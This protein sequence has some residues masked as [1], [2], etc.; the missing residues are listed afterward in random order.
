MTLVSDEPDQFLASAHDWPTQSHSLF[1]SSGVDQ[2]HT[3]IDW[4][5]GHLGRRLGYK[6]AAEMLG[7]AMVDAHASDRDLLVFPWLHC[8]RHWLELELKNLLNVC[9]RISG[10]E[11][12]IRRSHKVLD[13]WRELKPMLKRLRPSD[14]VAEMQILDRLI[15]EMAELDPDSMHSRYPVLKDGSPTLTTRKVL[16]V[17]E[18]HDAMSGIAAFFDGVEGAIEHDEEIRQEMREYGY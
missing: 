8:W 3:F 11:V 17:V 10:E 4:W 5:P 1:A 15:A 2:L 9:E 18:V 6:Q 12:K 16:D 14:G 7:Q 13:L